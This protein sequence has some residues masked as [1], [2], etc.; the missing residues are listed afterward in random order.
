MWSYHHGKVLSEFN[1]ISEESYP[2]N[3]AY[4]T[5]TLSTCSDRRTKITAFWHVFNAH[6]AT[7]VTFW[8][9][10]VYG[11]TGEVAWHS[12]HYLKICVIDM[13]IYIHLLNWHRI[14]SILNCLC[15]LK[16]LLP[17]PAALFFSV[18]YPRGP[19]QQGEA[20]LV[21]LGPFLASYR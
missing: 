20:L 6:L 3:P 15:T 16:E 9:Y 7:F 4:K 2:K 13:G 11:G 14:A 18:V 10:F 1:K 21:L 17:A 5:L 19:A 12:Q 8:V